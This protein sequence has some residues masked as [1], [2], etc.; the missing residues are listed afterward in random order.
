MSLTTQLHA[1]SKLPGPCVRSTNYYWQK[2]Y[3]VG[4]HGVAGSQGQ[5]I[6]HGAAL[7]Y[8][9]GHAARILAQS[10]RVDHPVEGPGPR[11]HSHRDLIA[12][13]VDTHVLRHLWRACNNANTVRMLDEVI[14]N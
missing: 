6:A 10:F 7:V 13:T 11:L 1:F 14:S 2:T 8:E 4:T 3:K 12:V 9:L 5:A